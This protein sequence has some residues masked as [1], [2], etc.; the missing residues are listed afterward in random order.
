MNDKIIDLKKFMPNYHEERTRADIHDKINGLFQFL[1]G[2]ADPLDEV[3]KR[4]DRY[5]DGLITY[6]W[7]TDQFMII[8]RFSHKPDCPKKASLVSLGKICSKIDFLL[9]AETKVSFK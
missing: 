6:S 4:D 7:I 8:A 9:M 1:L 2:Y 3:F 5:N